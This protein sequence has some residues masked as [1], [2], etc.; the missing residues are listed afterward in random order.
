MLN[1]ENINVAALAERLVAARKAAEITQEEAA[2]RLGMSRPTFIAIEKG[3]RRPRPEELTQLAALY[4]VSLNRLLRGEQKPARLNPHLRAMRGSRSDGQRE[5]DAAISLLTDYIEDYQYLEELMASRPVA[6]FPPPVRIPTGSIDKFAEHC[7]QEERTRLNLGQHQPLRAPRLALEEAG[8]HI[9]IDRIDSKLAGLYVFAPEFGYCILVN[10][11]HPGERRRWTIAHEYGHFLAERDRPG[12][13]YLKPARRR[14]QSER[15]ADSFAAAFLMPKTGV[16]RRFYE[17][18]DRTG[19][20]KVGDLCRMAEYFGVSLMAMTLRLESLGLI[21]RNSWN[22]IR[23]SRVP[24]G[25][26]REEAGVNPYTDE[27]PEDPYPVRYKLLA[28]Q[29]YLNGKL[30]EGQI[31]KLLRCTRIEAREIVAKCSEVPGDDESM[32]SRVAVSL[33]HSLIARAAG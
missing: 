19:D 33:T 11:V 13:D 23:A 32:P 3:T 20:F 16:R 21:P 9:F 30:S 7:A 18:M 6:G 27:D 8:M 17:D 22:E 15:F 24:V 2:T 1:Y 12:V 29:A 28:V 26:I 4:G 25:R 10:S 31:A 5:L 14:S